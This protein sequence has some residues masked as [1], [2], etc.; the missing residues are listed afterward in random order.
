MAA[1]LVAFLVTG[2]RLKHAGVV[3]VGDE[4]DMCSPSCKRPAPS[5]PLLQNSS[6]LLTRF[7]VCGSW[8]R[9]QKR[10]LIKRHDVL[11]SG[12]VLPEQK[13][14]G[15]C[16]SMGLVKSF[17][18]A[19]V[20]AAAAVAITPRGFQPQVAGDLRVIYGETLGENGAALKKSRG[21]KAKPRSR[22]Q[23]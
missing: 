6:S 23:G 5:V 4:S 11:A 8:L 17:T 16:F 20:A 21:I 3:H 9:G 19:L 1:V 12:I 10:R 2:N 14:V 13:Y 15:I 7:H 22:A 18:A